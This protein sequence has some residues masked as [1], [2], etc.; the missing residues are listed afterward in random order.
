MYGKQPILSTTFIPAFLIEHILCT[1]FCIW[2][3]PQP[4]RCGELIAVAE[5]EVVSNSY[6][7]GCM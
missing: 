6:N 1:G 5:L 2:H 4:R 7:E 3:R